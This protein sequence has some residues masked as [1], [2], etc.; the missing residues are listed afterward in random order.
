MSPGAVAFVGPAVECYSGSTY[1]QEPRTVVAADGQRCAI[2]EVEQRWRTPDGPAFRVRTEAG[3]RLDLCYFES[4]DRWTAAV[5]PM[6]EPAA[7]P[8]G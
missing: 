5:L 8:C 6:S 1:A 2:V 4:E 7:S 3:D